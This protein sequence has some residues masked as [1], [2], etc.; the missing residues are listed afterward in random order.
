MTNA[1]SMLWLE[2]DINFGNRLYSN[3]KRNRNR[4]SIT[5]ESKYW[6]QKD[7]PKVAYCLLVTSA[8]QV[9]LSAV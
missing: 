3:R 9:T 6:I 8:K 4:Y 2:I 7:E 1:W 5:S